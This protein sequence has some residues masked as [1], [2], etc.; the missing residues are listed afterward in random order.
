[1]AFV[2]D[3][4]VAIAWFVKGQATGYTSA[5]LR[6][7]ARERLH[8]PPLWHAEF[9]NALV[10]LAHR[11][12]V[13]PERLGAIFGEIEELDLATDADPPK[14]RE[15]AE[16]SRRF[17]LSAFDAVYLELAMRR[18]L[19]IAVRDGPLIKAAGR[20]GVAAA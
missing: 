5:L 6:R 18:A 16:V 13:A 7:A 8:V 20:A 11:R 4:S 19:P 1:M 14:A 9:G 15:I 17:S 2:L 3:A 10:V 12:K